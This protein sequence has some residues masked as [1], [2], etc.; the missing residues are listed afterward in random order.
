MKCRPS[1]PFELLVDARR[2]RSG[3]HRFAV[4]GLSASGDHPCTDLF[5]LAGD[6]YPGDARIGG[7]EERSRCSTRPE[8]PRL[9]CGCSSQLSCRGGGGGGRFCFCSIPWPAQPGK[10][11]GAERP[12]PGQLLLAGDRCPGFDGVDDGEGSTAFPHLEGSCGRTCPWRS[13]CSNCRLSLY[14]PEFCM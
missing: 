3:C 7:G 2:R 6:R 13:C 10:S 1:R 5:L 8:E 4:A 9:P 12:C 11:D 14:L